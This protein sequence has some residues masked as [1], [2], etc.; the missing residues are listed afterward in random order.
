MVNDGSKLL[1]AYSSTN[2]THSAGSYLHTILPAFV[3]LRSGGC[4]LTPTL[5]GMLDAQTAGW[6]SACG[7]SSTNVSNAATVRSCST[8]SS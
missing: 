3:Q 4:E 2:R 8:S 7:L 5:S 6:R 1:H